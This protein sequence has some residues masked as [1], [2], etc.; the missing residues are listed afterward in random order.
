[1]PMLDLLVICSTAFIVAGLTLYSGFGLGTLLMPVMAL[2]LPVDTAVAVT[3]VVH[4][5]ANLGKLALV[6][7]HAV[8]AV[9]LKFGLPAFVAAAAGAWALSWLSG[10]GST[11]PY[12]LFGHQFEIVPV[13]AV[14][15]VLL[16]VFVFLEVNGHERSMPVDRRY[17]PVGGL[18]SG[19]FGG[20]SGHQGAF[21]SAFLAKSGLS[22]HQFLG[23]SVVIACLVDFARLGMYGATLSLHSLAERPG[24]L[25]AMIG[26]ALLG[27][28]LSARY[29]GRVT[30]RAIQ[31]LIAAMLVV[32][33]VGLG[34]GLL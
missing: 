31:V 33:A 1:M 26:A 32:I 20:L 16:L 17:L 5:I 18:L 34:T 19:F 28:F 8:P 24:A 10:L 29:I 6:G 13:K 9:V 3:A 12:R 2:F 22:T 23:T 27:T 30:M 11:L 21:R 15:A 14:I 7:R 25:L 4:F